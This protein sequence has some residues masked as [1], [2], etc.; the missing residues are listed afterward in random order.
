MNCFIEDRFPVQ[1]VVLASLKPFHQI[2]HHV[3]MSY[4]VREVIAFR[5]FR[6][7]AFLNPP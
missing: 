3:N 6:E 1:N 5:Y 4:H 2:E 7:S